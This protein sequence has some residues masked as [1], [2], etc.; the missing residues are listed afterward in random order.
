MRVMAPAQSFTTTLSLMRASGPYPQAGSPTRAT[1]RV[2]ER[3]ARGD[4]GPV[5]IGTSNASVRGAPLG[6]LPVDLV[7]IDRRP[8]PPPCSRTGRVA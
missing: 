6:R 4:R 5:S 2:V 8:F 7:F 3:A 1:K